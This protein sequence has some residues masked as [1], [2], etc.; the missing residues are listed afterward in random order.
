[1]NIN[2]TDQNFILNLLDK[3]MNFSQAKSVN[4]FNFYINSEKKEDL[5]VQDTSSA[6]PSPTQILSRVE[7]DVSESNLSRI[8]NIN[9]N[10]NLEN[11]MNELQ[12]HSNNRNNLDTILENTRDSILSSSPLENMSSPTNFEIYI[13]ENNSSLESDDDDHSSKSNE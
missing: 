2:E 1:M 3:C 8:E 11:I 7:S 9:T 6:T 10:N 13:T 12:L 4:N 5:N